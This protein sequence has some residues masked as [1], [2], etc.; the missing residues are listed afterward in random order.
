VSKREIKKESG[1]RGEDSDGGET[2]KRKTE[3]NRIEG[4]HSSIRDYV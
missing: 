1:K 4:T 3:E 2:G